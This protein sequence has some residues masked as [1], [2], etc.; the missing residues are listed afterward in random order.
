[1]RMTPAA[2]EALQRAG[3]SRRDFI[4]G[5]GALIVSYSAAPL[6]D[7]RG[8]AQGQFGTQIQQVDPRLIGRASC[9]ERVYDDV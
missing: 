5:A 7:L 9:R 2:R 8:A 1:M 4:R 6:F 3:F